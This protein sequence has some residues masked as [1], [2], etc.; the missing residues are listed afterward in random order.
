MVRDCCE[1]TAAP[2][3][4]T[5]GVPLFNWNGDKPVSDPKFP[6]WKKGFL[7]AKDHGQG[8]TLVITGHY[9]ANEKDGEKLALARA[10][11]IRDMLAPELP[12]NRVRLAAK[13]VDDGLAEGGNPMESASFTW[14]KMVLKKEESAVI[15]SDKDVILLFPFNSTVNVRDAKVDAYLKEL[16]EKHKAT[17]ATFSV[18]GHTDNVG[19]D[20]E[21]MK[22]GLD[23]A[24]SVAKILMR[25]GIAGNRIQTSSK[26][27]SE[28]VADNSTDEGRQQNRRVVITVTNR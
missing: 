24:K 8:D 14:S 5:T 7:A 19:T 21:N 13:M 6:D 12:A 15:E 20:E 9:R 18:T 26:G 22:M 1:E 2:A 17:N 11:A 28:P 4:E 27:K 10:A 16:C 3:T 25:N 23:R